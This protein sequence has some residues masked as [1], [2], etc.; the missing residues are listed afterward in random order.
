MLI[1]VVNRGWARGA[2]LWAGA[3]AWTSNDRFVRPPAIQEILD[4]YQ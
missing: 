3:P 4:G 2:G 1:V